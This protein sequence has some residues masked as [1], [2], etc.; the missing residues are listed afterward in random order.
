MQVSAPHAANTGPGAMDLSG[1]TILVTG[2][3]SGIGREICVLLS[4]LNARLVSLD[5][6]P[7]IIHNLSF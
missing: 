2:A 3:S 6:F 1:R 4:E 5:H 7:N